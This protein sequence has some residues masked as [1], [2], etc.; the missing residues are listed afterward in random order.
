MNSRVIL[1]ICTAILVIVGLPTNALA[2]MSA[3]EQQQF[4]KM[5]QDIEMLKKQVQVLAREKRMQATSPPVIEI[6]PKPK[7][8]SLGT[9]PALGNP[10]AKVALIEFADYQCLYCERFYRQSFDSL[11]RRFIDSGKVMY[12]FRD[13]PAP[14]RPQ[15]FP[16]AV[17]AR[18]AG[19]QGKYYDMQALL[20]KNAKSLSADSYSAFAKKLGLDESKFS[21]CLLDENQGERIKQDVVD[22]QN[23]DITGTPTFYVGTVDGNRI[24]NP[25]KIVGALPYSYFKQS[26]E[27]A[28]KN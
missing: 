17:A 3:S 22:A 9:S 12:V 13:L 19:D 21:A 7:S 20:F 11:K 28:L 14:N 4:Q 10:N 26:L 23:L 24:V 25:K 15:A 6:A 1:I 8:V 27:T 16:A 2:D 18:C 5:Q